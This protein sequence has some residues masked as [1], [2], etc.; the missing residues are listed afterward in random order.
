MPLYKSS[1]VIQNEIKN[2]LVKFR[3]GVIDNNNPTE[4]T[5][6]HF[7]AFIDSLSDAYSSDW[8]SQKFMGRAESFY[9]FQGFERSIS[10]GWTVAAQSKQE[11]IPMYQKLNYLASS[12]SGDYSPEG[13][14]RG[15]LITLTMGGWFYEQPGFITGMTLDVD[16]DSPWDIAIN[17]TGNS[18]STV[19]EL[20][21]IIKVSGFSFTPIHEFV[22]R[23]QQNSFNNSEF[24]G[25]GANWIESYGRERYLALNNG[26]NNNYDAGK[27]GFNYT[28]QKPLS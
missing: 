21:M 2:D 13:F 25:A 6:I 18:D 1:G 9:K 7:R 16:G 15:N 4:K 10:I 11:L 22:P 28:P 3:I 23:V 20:P 26:K 19:K 27:D 5:Y 8:S 12:L 14:M 17:D 24:E